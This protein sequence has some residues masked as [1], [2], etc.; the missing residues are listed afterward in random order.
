MK[1]LWSKNCVNTPNSEVIT[2]NYFFP[3]KNPEHGV[4]LMVGSDFH[5]RDCYHST[6]TLTSPIFP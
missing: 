6:N 4:D 3:K 2:P 1:L 5:L